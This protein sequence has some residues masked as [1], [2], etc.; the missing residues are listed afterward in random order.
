M[1]SALGAGGTNP[2]GARRFPALATIRRTT[3]AMLLVV[4]PVGCGYELPEPGEQVSFDTVDADP[5]WSPGG[6]LIAFAS[7]RGPGGIYVIDPE[8]RRMRRLWRGD[9]SDLDWSPDGRMIAFV[10]SDGVYVLRVEAAHRRRVLRGERFS[11]P[12]WA[13][14]G[15]RLAIVKEEPDLD[16]AIFT[17]R[18]DGRGLRRLLPR[19]RGAV[20][21]ARPGSP[22]AVSET[23]PAW[24][25]D[26]RSIAFQA[27]DGEIVAA[28]IEDGRRREIVGPGA[29]EPA[30]SP[31]GKLIAYQCEGEVCVVNADGSGERRRLAPDGGD[32][33][34]APDS[35]RLVFEHYLYGGTFYGSSPQS[36]SLVGV[37]EGDP[38]KL[39]FGDELPQSR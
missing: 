36:L 23:E 27:G 39:T 15:R 21:D 38:R 18:P 30:W 33:T 25:P 11:L 28:S 34:W 17:V 14:D 6:R 12:A 16:T 29:Y 9:A 3:V 8:G 37:E 7:T 32:P 24:S 5:D 13:P 20:G 22:G 1:K 26:G 2:T 19:H 31:D 4:A 10:G 35:R